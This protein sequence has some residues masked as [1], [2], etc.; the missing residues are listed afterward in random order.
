[1]V[2]HN[3]YFPTITTNDDHKQKHDDQLL[4]ACEHEIQSGMYMAGPFWLTGKLS[5]STNLEKGNSWRTWQYR[6]ANP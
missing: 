6:G 4:Q 1:M 2:V 3:T 5:V